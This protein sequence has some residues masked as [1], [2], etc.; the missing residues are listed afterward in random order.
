[1][2]D[3]KKYLTE[4][5]KAEDFEAAIIMGIYD[6]QGKKLDSNSGVS[7]SAEK[8]VIGDE[9]AREAGRKIAK[10][11]LAIRPDLRNAQCQQTGRVKASLT[12]FWTSYGATNKTPKTDIM[13]GQMR[14]SLKV[15]V[16]QLMSGGKSESLATF[17]AAIKNSES[18]LTETVQYK[19]ALETL[20]NFVESSVAPTQ[21][22]PLI[23]SGENELVNRGEAAHK[24]IMQEMEAMFSQSEKFQVEFVKEA[25]TGREKFG[26]DSPATAE[27]ILVVDHSGNSVDLK[28]ITDEYCLEVAKKTKIQARFKTS[29]KKKG[30]EKVGYSFWSV[31][32]LIVNDKKLKEETFLEEGIL[33]RFKKM[34]SNIKSFFQKTVDKMIDFLSIEPIIKLKNLINF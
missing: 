8:A 9:K 6:E 28:P 27:W 12:P 29:S 34:L 19:S 15:G 14:V 7:S 30:G 13:L 18:S 11:L 24:K 22:R 32:S 5:V 31:I 2:K 23:K 21:L 10:K 4:G 25:M 1:M 26:P 20:D 17:H 16:S 33:D 3:Y